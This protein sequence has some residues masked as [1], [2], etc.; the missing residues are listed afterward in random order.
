MFSLLSDKIGPVWDVVVSFSLIVFRS[1]L[2]NLGLLL[3]I[4]ETN[5]SSSQ[6]DF[7][8]GLTVSVG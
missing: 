3:M 2:T 8:V 6:N 5:V 7:V 1:S 4:H